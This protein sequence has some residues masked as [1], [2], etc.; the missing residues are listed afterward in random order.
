MSNLRSL[1]PVLAA[2]AAAALPAWL[3]GAEPK[4]EPRAARSV[5]LGYAAPD[6]ALFY[7]EVT[8]EES[9]PGTYFCVCGFNHGY[10]GIQELSGGRGKV[11]IFSVWDPG[12]QNDPGKV[13][14][15][16]RVEVLHQDPDVQVS[17]FGGEGTGAKSMMKFDWQVG[18]TYRFLVKA[19]VEDKKTAYAAYLYQN[20]AQ[21]W[22]HLA[23]FRTP[24]GGELLKGCYSFIEDFRRD[25]KSVTERRRAVFGSG[26]VRTAR[27]EW[28]SLTRATFTGDSTPLE[29]VD[30][31]LRDGRFFLATGGDT[32][33]HTPLNAK[34][35]R[36]P[37]G[38]ELPQEITGGTP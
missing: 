16:K 8:V 12:S 30:A 13:D 25:G 29:N 2:V 22:K 18:Q 5:H 21:K 27:G 10:F 14:A 31:G 34:I 6:A 38:L 1:G 24:T 15:E 4:S 36:L 11:A 37:P 32:A 7:N 9:Q 20:P 17:R 19:A 26:W 28:V 35:S 3:P 33:N 23:T